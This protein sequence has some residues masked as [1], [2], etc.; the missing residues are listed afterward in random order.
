MRLEHGV[1]PVVHR[2]A[3][4]VQPRCMCA[5][6]PHALVER[7]GVQED[8][9]HSAATS[10][11][12]AATDGPQAGALDPVGERRPR[13]ERDAEQVARPQQPGQERDVGEAEG[14]AAQPGRAG[15]HRVQEAELLLEASART[16]L[17]T[18]ER[19]VR[20]R[21]VVE[22]EDEQP[23]GRTLARIVRPQRRL[24]VAL[25][26]ELRDHRRL[27]QDPAVLVEHRHLAGRVHLVQP[28]GP[29]GEVDLDRLVRDLLLGQDDPDP[30]AVGAASSVV[31]RDQPSHPRSAPS[32]PI[33]AASDS[34]S[35]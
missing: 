35:S 29:V 27:G 7:E 9:R 32:S 12:S 22:A 10:I 33:A 26:Q 3:E 6:A 16:L 15:E 28:R 5:R 4:A 23:S 14:A 24:G 17:A 8:D 31:E 20:L 18:P 30:G 25:V 11:C 21:E 1:G 34:S 19:V 2:V 13:L